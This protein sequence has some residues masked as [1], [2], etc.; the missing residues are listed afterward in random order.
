MHSHICANKIN[1]N[2]CSCDFIIF[3]TD[4]TKNYL[5]EQN[6]S[7]IYNALLFVRRIEVFQKINFDS[8]N[9]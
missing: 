6:K 1:K 3:I 5:S 8:L 4:L 7:T 2:S 9:Y